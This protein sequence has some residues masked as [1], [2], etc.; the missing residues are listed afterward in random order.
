MSSSLITKFFLEYSI[1]RVYNIY[2]SK[3]LSNILN[4]AE[5]ETHNPTNRKQNSK[6]SA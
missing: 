4:G 1:K 2:V 3:L 6:L 5:N